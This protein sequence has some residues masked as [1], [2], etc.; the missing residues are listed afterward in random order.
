MLGNQLKCLPSHFKLL[1][2]ELISYYTVRRTPLLRIKTYFKYEL[3]S[4]G[5]HCNGY[6]HLKCK[7]RVTG[8]QISFQLHLAYHFTLSWSYSAVKML[9]LHLATWGSFSYCSLFSAPLN[10]IIM[11]YLSHMGMMNLELFAT[12][13]VHSF[14]VS[15]I[16]SHLKST[17]RLFVCSEIIHVLQ[18]PSSSHRIYST[19]FIKAQ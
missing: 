6:Y 17:L 3:E 13:K 4:H 7:H 12:Y 10:T 18:S 15:D 14:S 16:E 9:V 8:T 19:N 2:F 11:A 1:K 5:N